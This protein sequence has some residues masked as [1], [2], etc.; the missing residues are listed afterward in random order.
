MHFQREKRVKPEKLFQ[1]V[2]LI[3]LMQL[4]VGASRDFALIRVGYIFLMIEKHK[5]KEC[6]SH[7]MIYL[8]KSNLRVSCPKSNFVWACQH[9]R[10]RYFGVSYSAVAV[11][12]H[13]VDKH[14]LEQRTEILFFTFLIHAC[15]FYFENIFSFWKFW[16]KKVPV[17]V[18][19]ERLKGRQWFRFQN[20]ANHSDLDNIF[21][22]SI[23][24]IIK[25]TC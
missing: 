24:K 5:T 20:S 2:S 1:S 14:Q 10:H 25:I 17:N 16:N 23:V 9:C 18:L 6:T 19:C 3:P 22:D 4:I 11:T 8:S 12:I 7:K 21:F 13:V 15:F